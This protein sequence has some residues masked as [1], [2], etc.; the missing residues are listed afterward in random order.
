M[1]KDWILFP[2]DEEQ[3]KDIPSQHFNIVLEVLV[4]VIRQE[5]EI[6]DI[7]IGKKELYNLYLQIT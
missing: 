1:V 4:W 6:K 3:N 2:E 7:H 5:K